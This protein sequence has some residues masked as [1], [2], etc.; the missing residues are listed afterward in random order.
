MTKPL[1]Y[2]VKFTETYVRALTLI[3]RH[4]RTIAG[5]VH[6]DAEDLALLPDQKGKPLVGALAGL[7][8][9]R[10]SRQRYRIIYRIDKHALVVEVLFAGI[11][12]EG[13]RQDVYQIAE[14]TFRKKRA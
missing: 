11:R 7:W 2:D 12:R 10:S 6:V 9:R 14:R 4:G 8:S 1:L 5:R 13:S 3:K